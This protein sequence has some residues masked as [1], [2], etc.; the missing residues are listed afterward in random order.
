MEKISFHNPPLGGIDHLPISLAFSHE[1]NWVLIPF[2]FNPAWMDHPDF[3]PLVTHSWNQWI[4]GSLVHIWE[5]KINI[6]K[7]SLKT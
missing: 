3:F 7:G 6:T 4:F 5:H 2:K 1:I